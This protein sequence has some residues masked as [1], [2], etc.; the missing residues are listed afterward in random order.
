MLSYLD[1]SSSKA[2]HMLPYLELSFSAWCS[3]ATKLCRTTYHGSR[4]CAS[5][6]W[7]CCAWMTSP[8]TPSSP[9][10]SDL[11]TMRSSPLLHQRRCRYT[12]T[13]LLHS[14]RR[15]YSS[16][17]FFIHAGASQHIEVRGSGGRRMGACGSGGHC[18]VTSSLLVFVWWRE[19][20]RGCCQ[21]VTAS[22]TLFF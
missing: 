10:V 9:M 19:G 16:F 14:S 1:T 20:C 7:R 4:R 3:M 8:M 2:S 18:Q 22:L 21:A 11:A 5:V 6:L 15:P 13:P 17:L 12:S